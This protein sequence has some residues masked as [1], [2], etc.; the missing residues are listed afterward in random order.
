M[1]A[2]DLLSPNHALPAPG[3]AAR[4]PGSRTIPERRGPLVENFMT[5]DVESCDLT[6][7]LGAAAMI[8]WRRDCGIVPVVEAPTQRVVGVITDRDICMAVATQ[9]RRA[10]EIQVR[11]VISGTVY[12]VSPQDDVRKALEVMRTN[13]VRRLPVTGIDGSLRGILSLNDIA[14]RSADP[15]WAG[16]DAIRSEEILTAY[17]AICGHLQPA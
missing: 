1:R 15:Q 17:R 3:P 11:H 6:T 16:P 5:P 9:G 10:H 4:H 8:M 7:D 14:L 13:Q 2:R 12:A